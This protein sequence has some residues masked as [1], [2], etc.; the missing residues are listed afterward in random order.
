MGKVYRRDNRYNRR[1]YG[2]CS[3][4]GDFFHR[5][6]I[7][8]GIAV[9]AG[10]LALQIGPALTDC[11]VSYSSVPRFYRVPG[12]TLI[13]LLKREPWVCSE[14]EACAAGWRKARR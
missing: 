14:A 11:N 8:A 9:I 6:K 5:A 1:K 7:I 13:N 10:L 4:S 2:K 3:R 12:Q